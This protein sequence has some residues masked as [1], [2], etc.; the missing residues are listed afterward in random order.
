MLEEYLK[1][2][3]LPLDLWKT[4]ISKEKDNDMY[5]HQ[6]CH[7]NSVFALGIEVSQSLTCSY[8]L[9]Q[10]FPKTL[11]LY[12][13]AYWR[14]TFIFLVFFSPPT[15]AS[16]YSIPYEQSNIS[17][18]PWAYL[19]QHFQVTKNLGIHKKLNNLSLTLLQF[20]FLQTHTHKINIKYMFIDFQFLQKKKKIN[21]NRQIW[22]N[23]M[24]DDYLFCVGSF[25]TIKAHKVGFWF[26]K[27][28]NKPKETCKNFH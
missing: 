14:K 26:W 12:N 25:V 7:F 6:K 20:K 11:S 23:I 10:K 13:I 24:R 28:A 17:K 1:D 9:E 4:Y 18:H 19:V 15:Q 27:I 2:C 22:Y 8:V 16:S 5:Q 21:T 3:N